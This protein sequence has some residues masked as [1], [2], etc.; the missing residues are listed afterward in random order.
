MFPKRFF[1]FCSGAR[2]ER[3]WAASRLNGTDTGRRKILHG[4]VTLEENG[5]AR[6]NESTANDTRCNP[7]KFPIRLYRW[8]IKAIGCHIFVLDFTKGR[9]REERSDSFSRPIPI[10]KSPFRNKAFPSLDHCSPL[11]HRNRVNS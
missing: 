2:G 3:L 10:A 11:N 5:S 9:I 1:A 8:Q 6:L 7:A 4:M